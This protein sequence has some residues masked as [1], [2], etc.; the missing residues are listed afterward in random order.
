MGSEH[1]AHHVGA[2]LFQIPSAVG[3][4]TFAGGMTYWIGEAMRAI[5]CT[6]IPGSARTDQA[7]K[8]AAANAAHLGRLLANAPDPA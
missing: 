5:G 4:T 8:S 6:D 2:E 3:F 7:T 1:E